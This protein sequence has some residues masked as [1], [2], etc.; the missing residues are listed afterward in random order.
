MFFEEE[1][2]AEKIRTACRERLEELYGAGVPDE[3]RDRVEWEYEAMRRTGSTETVYLHLV[4]AAE[5]GRL[6]EPLRI[7]GTAA[8]S[9]LLWLLGKSG[10]DPNEAYYYCEGCGHYRRIPDP[11][12]GSE[13]PEA[14]C[15]VCGKRMRGRGFSLDERFV[16]HVHGDKALYT[17]YAVSSAFFEA[18]F[19]LIRE[20]LP[21]V[22]VMPGVQE[23]QVSE[24]G[25]EL[26]RTGL[27]LFPEGKNPEDYP[28]HLVT[29]KDGQRGFYADYEAVEKL[30]LLRIPLLCMDAMRQEQNPERAELSR[31][32][33][34]ACRR[35]SNMD[36]A[37]LE[38]PFYSR[39]ELFR[40]LVKAGNDR[41]T[42]FEIADFVRKGRAFAGGGTW[43][44]KWQE[45]VKKAKMDEET[46]DA[47]IHARYLW[48]EGSV[49]EGLL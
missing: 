13:A 40:R 33:R 8:D 47:C 5:A 49:L 41:D 43:Q 19:R 46:A 12:Y 14:A 18:A 48:T 32:V 9:I 42:A 11:A 36:P 3:I 31:V 25:T 22:P 30:G 29:L 15:P 21:E 44:E 35:L 28:E 16:W 20:L 34:D 38:Y 17:E 24:N 7:R 37:F 26:L 23:G 27:L 39:E 4:L 45:Y 2:I 10:T 1:V 6:G